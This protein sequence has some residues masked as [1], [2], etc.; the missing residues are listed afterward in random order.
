VSGIAIVGLRIVPFFKL[1]SSVVDAYQAP[2]EIVL[3]KNKRQ[4]SQLER[5]P[6][7]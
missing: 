1:S 4:F 3:L 6:S 7:P 2:W 5:L